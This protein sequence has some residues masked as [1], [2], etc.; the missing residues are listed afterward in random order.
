[1]RRSIRVINMAGQLGFE[2]IAEGV[3][4]KHQQEMLKRIGCRY[5]QGE[6]YSVP[7][8]RKVFEDRVRASGRH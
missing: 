2:A 8:E 4:Y 7:L 1:M 3:E 6:L 5:F